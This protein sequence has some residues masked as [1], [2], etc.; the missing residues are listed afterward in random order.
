[1]LPPFSRIDRGS[2]YD[3]RGE[4]CRSKVQG[5]DIIKRFL[6]DLKERLMAAL[7][8][9]V[10]ERVEWPVVQHRAANGSGVQDVQHASLGTASCLQDSRRG[11]FHLVLRSSHQ[12]DVSAG[13][14]KG[15]RA[16]KA[17]SSACADH[18]CALSCKAG[19][20]TTR[21]GRVHRFAH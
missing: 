14:G 15:S 7:A 12:H 20:R 10:H 18:E 9:V 11:R 3:L 2:R 17:D 16:T 1:M 5:N 6:F 8:R 4:Q 21:Q 19:R 13:F